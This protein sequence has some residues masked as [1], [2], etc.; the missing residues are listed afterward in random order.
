[1][2]VELLPMGLPGG[3]DWIIA[4][5]HSM[6]SCPGPADDAR[7]VGDVIRVWGRLQ[8]RFHLR[9]LQRH[10]NQMPDE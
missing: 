8:V 5:G 1:M 9:T 3:L 2:A 7:S 10:C 6:S 4:T